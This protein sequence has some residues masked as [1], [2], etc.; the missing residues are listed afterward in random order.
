MKERRTLGDVLFYFKEFIIIF[1]ICYLVSACG[2]SMNTFEWKASES[3]PTGIPMEIVR[4]DLYAPDDSSVYVPDGVVINHGWGEMRS[5]HSVGPEK[6]ALPS[7]LE[8]TFFSYLENQFYQGVFELPYDEIVDAFNQG[9]ILVG[10]ESKSYLTRIVVGVAPGGAVSVWLT[11]PGRKEQ[12]FFGYASSSN[13]EWPSFKQNSAVPREQYVQYVVSKKLDS[14]LR[15]SVDYERKILEQWEQYQ[16]LYRWNLKIVFGDYSV[17]N[18]YIKFFN[19]E[20][21]NI[22]SLEK[23]LVE[24]PIPKSI[25]VFWPKV[26]GKTYSLEYFFDEGEI[27]SAF[28]TLNDRVSN[29]EVNEISLTLSLEEDVKQRMT[30]AVLSI[31]D[32]T[33]AMNKFTTESLKAK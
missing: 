27:I 8:I 30:T 29:T 3:A 19:G 17:N 9:Y 25:S 16:K 31:E 14:T 6:K 15:D 2:E 26:P 4:G 28:E 11:G 7:R 18:I 21:K 33:V 13:I 1:F 12:V 10:D 24:M 22:I 32:H 23:P 5:S 20:L